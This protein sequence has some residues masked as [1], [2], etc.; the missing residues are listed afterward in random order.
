MPKIGIVVRVL[1]E[2]ALLGAGAALLG[3]RVHGDDGLVAQWHFD[4]GSGSVLRDSSG[5]GN[6]GG[7][8]RGGG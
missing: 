7:A 4:E 8:V 6:D 5:N 3:V 1:R 2:I